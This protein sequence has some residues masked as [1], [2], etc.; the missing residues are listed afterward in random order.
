[1][2]I[3]NMNA[4]EHDAA[5]SSLLA[6]T[7]TDW[8]W[9][10]FGT[11]FA[12]VLANA[13]MGGGFTP[14]IS[15]PYGYSD[16]SLAVLFNIQRILEGWVFENPRSGYPF[17]SNWLD[18]PSSDA[19]TYSAFKVLTWMVGSTP[20]AFNLYFLLGFPLAFVAAFFVLRSLGLVPVFS[21][22]AALIFAFLPFH[23]LRLQHLYYTWYFVV[24]VFY[25]IAFR[26]F[27]GDNKA[28]PPTTSLSK[29]I[30][31]S[32]AMIALSSF[33]VYYALFG[34]IACSVATLSGIFGDAPKSSLRLGAAVGAL[35]ILGV[36]LN[37]TPNLVNKYSNGKNPEVAQRHP[38][39]SEIYGFKLLQLIMPREGHRS[40]KLAQVAADYRKTPLIN[41]N[42]W[43]SLGMLGSVGLL[44][45]F[46]VV[47]AS[48]VGRPPNRNLR[49]VACVVLVLFMFGT[50]GGL[51]ALFAHVISPAIRGWNRISIFI[52][53]GALLGLFMLLQAGLRRYFE[54]KWFAAI[55]AISAAL[56]LAFGLYD[57]TTPPCSAC[58]ALV[59]T[60]FEM[61]KTFVG[62][63]EN[64]LP[65]HSAIYQLPYMPFPEVPPLHRLP[66]Y[67]LAVGVLH[68]SSLRWSYGGM[69]GRE[70]DKFYRALAKE[71]P[72]RQ[73]EVI[74]RLGFSGVYI[75]KRG[76]ADHG[77]AV[78]AE[79]MALLGSAPTVMRA[80]GEA[81]FFRLPTAS[82]VD[83]D[84][85]NAGQLMEKSGYRAPIRTDPKHV[86]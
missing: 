40:E 63:I 59:Q 55:S 75:D 2:N 23:F 48:L 21:L 66:D 42:S 36:A 30:L 24:P 28:L 56:L 53:F 7:R 25:Y 4:A 76:F 50:I 71:P 81:V 68:S 20:A 32:L 13:L 54:A 37:I 17:G 33:G 67:S 45:L 86:P 69:K 47:I 44:G 9:L 60:T 70:G 16:D 19:A 46:F 1:M 12:A 65:R 83:L 49:L 14:N 58:N 85:L 35:I 15:Y 38:A 6:R 41:E 3:N 18:Y 72:Q 51:G 34:L 80:D 64:T 29:A 62:A 74:E 84:G 78:V 22:A 39:E 10:L 43:S 11:V 61:D 79:W 26:I 5:P 82:A 8:P 77:E 57:Q 27:R 73:L 52:G 31:F